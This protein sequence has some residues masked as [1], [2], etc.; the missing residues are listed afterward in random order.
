MEQL[1]TRLESVPGPRVPDLIGGL[2][3]A[4]WEQ[5]GS[6]SFLERENALAMSLLTLKVNGFQ[7]RM[8]DYVK[9]KLADDIDTGRVRSVL[10]LDDLAFTVLR[11]GES[12]HYLPTI[13]GE[14]ADPDRA[15]RVLTAILR[16][17]RPLD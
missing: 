12:F 8:L 16:P 6:R 1:W 2:L 17:D 9:G 3:H 13:T 11:V 7:P 10:P 15:T 4:V 14:A 5:P